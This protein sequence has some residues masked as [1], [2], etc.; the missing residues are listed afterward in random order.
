MPNKLPSMEIII[1]ESAGGMSN[2]EEIV[3]V[4]VS[5]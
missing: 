2:P 5:R 1:D 3:T 4:E